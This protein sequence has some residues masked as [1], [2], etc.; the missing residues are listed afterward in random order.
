MTYSKAVHKYFL[1]AFYRRTNKKN[2]KSQILQYNIRHTNIFVMQNIIFSAK[3][4]QEKKKQLIVNKDDTSIVKVTCVCNTT[5]VFLKYYW[6]V[7]YKN[8]NVAM[9]LEL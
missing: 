9:K 8:N 7:S 6:V 2:Y 5:N 3:F 4:E 1:E